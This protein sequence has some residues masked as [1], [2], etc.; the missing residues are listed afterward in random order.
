MRDKLIENKDKLKRY[1]YRLFVLFIGLAMTY[2]S[3][4]LCL[5]LM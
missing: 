1:S 5:T 2:I 3:S 4:V